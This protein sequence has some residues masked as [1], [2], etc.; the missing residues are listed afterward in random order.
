[1]PSFSFGSQRVA[2]GF[3]FAPTAFEKDH[4]GVW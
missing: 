4:K 3:S 2:S 1:L